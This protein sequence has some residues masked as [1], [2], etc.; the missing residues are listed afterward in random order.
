[1]YHQLH[2]VQR[3]VCALL[4]Q[5]QQFLSA[6]SEFLREQFLGHVGFLL[7]QRARFVETEE[8]LRAQEIVREEIQKQQIEIAAAAEAERIRVVAQGEADGT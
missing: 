8:T 3:R 7:F 4:L 6:V 2:L 1:M 5:L